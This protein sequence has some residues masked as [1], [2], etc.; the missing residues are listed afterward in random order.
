MGNAFITILLATGTTLLLTVVS[1]VI[2]IVLGAPVM[3]L[4]QSK[5]PLLR[6][7]YSTFVHLVRGVPALVWL[8]IAFFGITQ[9]GITL[10]PMASAI[11]TLS[12]I[13][14]ASMAEIYRGGIA[15]IAK[16]QWEASAALGLRPLNTALDV[17]FP[18]L[19]RAV[20]PTGATFV[21]GLLKESALASTIG[22]AEITFEAGLQVQYFGNGLTFFAFA[23]LIY[24]L[25]SLPLGMFS[26][27]LHTRL[28]RRYAVL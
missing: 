5:N 28:T 20:S 12:V 3:L 1:A 7:L 4:S 15:A 2:G 10:S 26:R 13:A 11:T 6:W 24:L 27:T 22:V 14:V 25:L 23:G 16:G 8:F 17:I 21:V 18:Q 9:L 19:L